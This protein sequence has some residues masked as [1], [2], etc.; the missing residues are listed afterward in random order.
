MR[1]AC[2]CLPNVSSRI[3]GILMR[4]RFFIICG[5]AICGLASVSQAADKPDPSGDW[6]WKTKIGDNEI[7]LTMKLKLEGDK[8][9]GTVKRNNNEVTIEDGTFKDNEVAFKTVREMDGRKFTVKYKGKL[10]GD[11]IKGKAEID[12][13]GETR[14]VDWEPKREKK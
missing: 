2:V 12:R 5:L 9:T 7:E 11:S 4:R 6:K 3:Q 14:T 8:L 1:W 10:D 13:N